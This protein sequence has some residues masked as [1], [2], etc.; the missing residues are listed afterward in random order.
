MPKRHKKNTQKGKDNRNHE[1][2]KFKITL[3]LA[4]QVI[5]LFLLQQYFTFQLIVTGNTSKTSQIH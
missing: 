2:S 1:K 3:Q 4:Y 5:L